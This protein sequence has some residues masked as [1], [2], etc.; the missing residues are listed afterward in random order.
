VVWKF[1]R[2]SRGLVITVEGKIN[3]SNVKPG[4]LSLSLTDQF[5]G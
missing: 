5:L 1:D 4:T 3:H 2:S